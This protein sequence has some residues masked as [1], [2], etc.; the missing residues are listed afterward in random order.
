MYP[1]DTQNFCGNWDEQS[2]PAVTS[3]DLD[4]LHGRYR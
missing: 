4:A 3:A 1:A 2:V